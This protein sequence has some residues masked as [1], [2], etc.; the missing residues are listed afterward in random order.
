[1]ERYSK[2]VVRS[3][4]QVVSLGDGEDEAREFRKQRW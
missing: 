1:M 3:G 2:R 4:F